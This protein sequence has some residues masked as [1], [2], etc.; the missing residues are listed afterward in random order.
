MCGQEMSKCHN[1]SYSRSGLFPGTELQYGQKGVIGLKRVVTENSCVRVNIF[2]SSTSHFL[3]R[4]EF[5]SA[6]H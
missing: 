2:K 4:C 5:G 6:I 3:T 1:H